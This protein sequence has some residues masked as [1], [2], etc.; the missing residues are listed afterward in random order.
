[1]G[2]D[3]PAPAMPPGPRLPVLQVEG[4]EAIP[5][6]VHGFYGRRGGASEGVFAALNLSVRVG[7]SPQAV[8]EN[9]CRLT[10]ALGGASRVVTMRQVHGADVATVDDAGA[11]VEE[12]DALVSR[13]RG[14]VLGVLTADCVPILLVAPHERVVAAVH[15]GWRGSV[16]GIARRAVQHL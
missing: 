1:N 15:A 3:L 2:A 4:W 11:A 10:H 12:A 16:A 13:A 7:D 14:V 5:D 9:W 8:E 6:L